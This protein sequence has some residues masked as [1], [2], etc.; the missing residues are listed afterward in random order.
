MSSQARAG[1]D[2][3]TESLEQSGTPLLGHLVLYS[4]YDGKVTLDNLTTWFR[5][6]DLDLSFL[7]QPIRPMDVFERLTGA[8]GL[9]AKYYLDDPAAGTDGRRRRRRSNG[10]AREALLMIRN[11]RR[12]DTGIVRH[13]VREVR[14]E[15]SK[16]LDYDTR[17]AVIAFERDKAPTS[18]VGAGALK[19]TPDYAAIA[20]LPELEQA[21]VH[22]LLDELTDTYRQNCAFLTADQMRRVVRDYLDALNA[23]R[24]RASGGV[25]FVAQPHVTTV[26]ALRTLV[27]RMGEDSGMDC[28]PLPNQEEMREMVIKA[29]TTRA[30]DELEELAQDLAAARRE[31]QTTADIQKLYKRFQSLQESAAAHSELLSS[32]LDDTA[33]AMNLVQA[34]L[35]SLLAQ[36]E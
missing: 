30:K 35:L 34:Q 19:V 28:I 21:R 16:R 23:I 32:S 18:A 13:L 14:D 26:R 8:R 6:L 36:A 33:N 5:E 27:G 10:N 2:G 24:V 22:Q 9:K 12:D 11:V 25:Y 15:G 7:P 1:F 17:L 4:V 20:E 31:S 3:Y 29:F